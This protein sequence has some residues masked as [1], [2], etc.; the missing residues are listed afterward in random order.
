MKKTLALIA[1]AALTAA[2]SSTTPEP[3]CG[4]Q[5]PTKAFEIERAVGIVYVV[6]TYE[7]YE[8]RSY[9]VG[10]EE[11]IVYYPEYRTK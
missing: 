4:C 5:Q 9:K 11:R 10:T 3:Q 1:L 2:C 7:S 8:P 6:D